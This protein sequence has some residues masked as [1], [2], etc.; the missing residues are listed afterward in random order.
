[1][2]LKGAVGKFGEAKTKQPFILDP[3]TGFQAECFF[4]QLRNT[5]VLRQQLKLLCVIISTSFHVICA[6]KK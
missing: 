3:K 6:R 4:F 1:M 5:F 2:A